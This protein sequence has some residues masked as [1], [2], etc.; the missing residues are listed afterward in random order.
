M[1][2]ATPLI[3]TIWSSTKLWEKKKSPP[4]PL[5]QAEGSRAP[6]W[7]GTMG[8]RTLRIVLCSNWSLFQRQR[9]HFVHCR[10]MCVPRAREVGGFRSSVLGDKYLSKQN[11]PCRICFRVGSCCQDRAVCQERRDGNGVVPQRT[12]FDPWGSLPSV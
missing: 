9:T 7:P 6:R 3:S 2:P 11:R 12:S 4:L 1:H 5:Q 10:Q 8:T